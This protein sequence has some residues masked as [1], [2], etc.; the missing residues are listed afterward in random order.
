MSVNMTLGK[1][2]GCKKP[3]KGKTPNQILKKL[4]AQNIEIY[5]IFT[6]E[7]R[8]LPIC[9]HMIENLEYLLKV[10]LL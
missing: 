4:L 6:G 7:K 3:E 8:C 1:F 2:R 5:T 9:C 10:F